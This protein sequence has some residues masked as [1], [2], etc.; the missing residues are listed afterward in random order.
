MASM[1]DVAGVNVGGVKGMF[2]NIKCMPCTKICITRVFLLLDMVFHITFAA[3]IMR[4][5]RKYIYIPQRGVQWT[6]GVVVYIIL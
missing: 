5:D 4:T 6:Q 1:T 2:L 3:S